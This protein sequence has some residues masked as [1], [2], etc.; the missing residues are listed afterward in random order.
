MVELYQK[1]TSNLASFQGTGLLFILMLVCLLGLFFLSKGNCRD[2]VLAWYSIFV[3]AVYFCPM[4]IL[5]TSARDDSDILYRILWLIPVGLIVCFTLVE[6]IFKL[7]SKVRGVAFAGAIL[8][9]VLAGDYLYDNP[10]FSK[11]ENVYH[12]PETVV[13]ICKEI[14]VPGREVRAC[15]PDEFIPFVR[16]YTPYVF[17]TYGRDNSFV[18]SMWEYSGAW[19]MLRQDV[20]DTEALVNELRRTYTHYLIVSQDVSFSKTLWNYDFGYLTGI[21]GYDIYIDNNY[22]EELGFSEKGFGFNP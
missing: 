20:V 15:F 4:W 16:Q 10:Y 3:L 7:K 22:Y 14:E 8:L 2:K 13:K 1:M 9:I 18:G 11:A 5:F 19:V 12:V 17:L 21:D 6:L